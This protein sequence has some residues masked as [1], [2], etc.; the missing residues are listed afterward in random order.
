MSTH[1][2]VDTAVDFK[3]GILGWIVHPMSHR[4]AMCFPVQ[5]TKYERVKKWLWAEQKWV[6]LSGEEKKP[7]IKNI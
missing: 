7:R 4:R 1:G 6:V 3:Q 5:V 2:L